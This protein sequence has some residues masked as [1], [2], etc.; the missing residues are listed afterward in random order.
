M[1]SGPIVQR[2]GRFPQ[3][4]LPEARADLTLGV[5]LPIAGAP[6]DPGHR[7]LSARSLHLKW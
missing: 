5:R 4:L 2:T 1:V 3:A 6:P 7:R